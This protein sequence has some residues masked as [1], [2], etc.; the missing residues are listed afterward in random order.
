M[1]SRKELQSFV[2]I[3]SP[4]FEGA[5]L[6]LKKCDLVFSKQPGSTF[7]LKQFIQTMTLIFMKAITDILPASQKKLLPPL[8]GHLEFSKAVPP[9]TEALLFR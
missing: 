3:P 7:S 5:R 1:K 9:S 2:W 8:K 4:G 6:L